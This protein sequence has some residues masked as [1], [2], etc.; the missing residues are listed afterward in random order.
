MNLLTTH[1]RI[2]APQ[3]R[4]LVLDVGIAMSPSMSL[5]FHRMLDAARAEFPMLKMAD[6]VICSYPYV[7]CPFLGTYEGR[8]GCLA[9]AKPCL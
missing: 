5:S 3:F 9:A 1:S 8:V 2:S 4:D 7:L 6:L